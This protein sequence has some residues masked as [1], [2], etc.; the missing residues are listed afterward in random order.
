MPRPNR[1]S[2]ADSV[3]P[4]VEAKRA[5]LVRDDHALDDHVRLLPTPGHTPRPRSRS[6]FGRDGDDAVMTGD[7]MHSP[8]QARYPELSLRFD[9]DPDAVRAARGAASSSAIATPHAVLHRAFPF[10]VD[11]ANHALGRGVSL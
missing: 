6:V 4:V 3:L 9:V 2:S 5:E 8:L 7:L 1:R 10:A 11:R